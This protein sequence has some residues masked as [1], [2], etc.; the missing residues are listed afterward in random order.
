MSASAILLLFWLLL[1]PEAAKVSAACAIL[2]CAKKLL[3][4]LFCFAVLSGF[5]TRSGALGLLCRIFEK[6]FH[7]LS[8]LPGRFVGTYLFSFLAGFPSGV[9]SALEYRKS[10]V[11]SR[12]DCARL[13][14]VSDNTG[15]ALPV[16]L[17]GGAVFSD[18]RLGVYIYLIQIAASL[19]TL[20]L[21]RPRKPDHPGKVVQSEEKITS[22]HESPITAFCAAVRSA[23]SACAALCGYVVIFTVAADALALRFPSV[24]FLLPF[25]EISNGSAALSALPRE[26]GF[27]IA[28]TALSFGGVCVQLQAADLLTNEKIPLTPHLFIKLVQ[29]LCAL[30]LAFAAVAARGFFIY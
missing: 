10:G 21:T 14:A 22:V 18:A 30:L 12:D 11:I 1:C 3:P 8:G 27:I 28:S 24:R 26:V 17:I 29:S 23:V 19:I 25:L 16:L 20:R 9:I 5:L 4:S 7:A 6:P 15:P 13:A 2:S